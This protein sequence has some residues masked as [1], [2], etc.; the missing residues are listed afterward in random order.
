MED[1]SDK[2]KR[3]T[4][5]TQP[6]GPLPVRVASLNG[7]SEPAAITASSGP[8][9]APL[10]SQEPEVR[11]EIETKTSDLEDE[12]VSVGLAQGEES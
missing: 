5:G 6:L 12:T 7:A 2:D 9:T 11:P 10:S 8:S 3:E 4:K 1:N